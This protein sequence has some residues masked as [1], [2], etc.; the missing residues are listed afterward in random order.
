M[1]T[2]LYGLNWDTYAGRV[3]PAFTNWLVEDNA[4]AVQQFYEKTRCAREEAIMPP[5]MK[6]IQTWVRAQSFIKRLPRGPHAAR[7]YRKLCS[8][9]QF[10]T[11]SDRY[12]YRYPPKL[13]QDDD[14]L[15]AVWG[16][17]IEEYCL[18]QLPQIQEEQANDATDAA[19]HLQIKRDNLP[20]LLQAGNPKELAQPVAQAEGSLVEEDDEHIALLLEEASRHI[21]P[22]GILLGQHP[23]ILHMRGWLASISIRAMALFELLACGRRTMPFGYQ[24]CEPFES[25]IGYLAPR[26]VWQLALC[27]RNVHPPN[28][29]KAKERYRQSRQTP[30]A[31]S[32]AFHMLD[33]M[34]PVHA[35]AFLKAVRAAASYGQG[36]ICDV[37]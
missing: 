35:N 2:Q 19:I 34:S 3:M 29:N 37:Q 26:E 36:L 11:L 16:A 18:S 7:E 22:E 28:E 8:A 10:T 4:E 5:A 12:V 6:A 23:S 30:A 27:L 32:E 31:Q 25:Y 14:A 33:E 21:G 24:A 17:I 15:R 20:E 9:E 1:I 13:Y